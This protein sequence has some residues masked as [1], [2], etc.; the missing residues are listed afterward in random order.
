MKIKTRKIN[1]DVISIKELK[2]AANYYADVLL[3]PQ[4][5]EKLTITITSEHMQNKATLEWMDKPVRPLEYKIVLNSD[6]KK[7]QTLISLAHEMVHAR[8]YI[9]GELKDCTTKSNCK[10]RKKEIDEENTY[11]YFLPFEIEA[12]G[13]EFGLYNLYMNKD[14]ELGRDARYKGMF[15]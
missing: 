6:Y 11:Y 5:K 8:Q 15:H 10:W 1:T 14:S 13:L 12:H 7:K 4:Q 3:T 2:E 9:R